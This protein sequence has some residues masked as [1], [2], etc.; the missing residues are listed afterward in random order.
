MTLD[1]AD[2]GDVEVKIHPATEPEEAVQ[3]QQLEQVEAK[4]N[5]AL[6]NEVSDRDAAVKAEAHKR[7]VGDDATLL[8]V[9]NNDHEI[10]SLRSELSTLVQK[11][12]GTSQFVGSLDESSIHT[13]QTPGTLT[14]GHYY[15]WTGVED[16]EI[17]AHAA[18]LTPALAGRVLQPGD[19]LIDN[20]TEYEIVRGDMMNYH[21]W[22]DLGTF[23]QFDDTAYYEIGALV[24]YNNHYYR[25]SG[26]ISPG[27]PFP[28]AGNQDWLDITPDAVLDHAKLGDLPD[29]DPVGALKDY[30]LAYDNVLQQWVAHPLAELT[31]RNISLDDLQDV[32][33]SGAAPTQG[34]VLTYNEVS[35]VWENKDPVDAATKAE[36][37]AV[38]A[39]ADAAATKTELKAVDDKIA[40][41]SAAVTKNTNNID[42]LHTQLGGLNTQLGGLTNTLAA[43]DDTNLVSPTNGQY[44]TYDATNKVWVNTTPQEFVRV[45]SYH[46]DKVNFTKGILENKVAISNLP[47]TLAEDD[48]TNIAS[49]SDGQALTFDG[50]S[51]KWVNTTPA[52]VPAAPSVTDFNQLKI[53]V[54]QNTADIT[55]NRN[56][57][58][59]LTPF[60]DYNSGISYKA[61]DYCVHGGYIWRAHVDNPGRAPVFAPKGGDNNDDNSS[62]DFRGVATNTMAVNGG[63]LLP[64]YLDWHKP[65][66]HG[67]RPDDFL[68]VAAAYYADSMQMFVSRRGYY[69]TAHPFTPVLGDPGTHGQYWIMDKNGNVMLRP[70]QSVTDWRNTKVHVFADINYGCKLSGVVKVGPSSNGRVYL[71][72]QLADVTQFE[73]NRIEHIGLGHGSQGAATARVFSDLKHQPDQ[74]HNHHWAITAD[75]MKAGSTAQVEFEYHHNRWGNATSPNGWLSVTMTVRYTNPGG[76]QCTD[77]TK[78]EIDWT[79]QQPKDFMFFSPTL[80]ADS[81]INLRPY[82]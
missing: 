60:G 33:T 1:P 81:T 8:Q 18:P 82:H 50:A 25:A 26:A 2:Y 52:P 64:G 55:A 73:Y 13:A 5:Q 38:K 31:E 45:S 59:D 76:N 53:D 12:T 19:W 34:Q 15:L 11:L 61:G 17:P 14:S 57:L 9:Q 7:T 37:N 66:F 49:P 20:G 75:D 48:D 16:Y 6:A 40:P 43:D 63:M 70:E 67:R 22:L 78:F 27:E 36:L 62:W 42:I 46:A 65:A 80:E 29:V 58:L 10:K 35:K 41:I 69:N 54:G 74:T 47:N 30:V 4:L 79:K 44:L 68:S 56:N 21:R 3:L 72:L 77:T 32:T 23:K 24:R 39:T 51:Q 71:D 28:G